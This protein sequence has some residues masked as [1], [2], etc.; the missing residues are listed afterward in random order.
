MGFF[1]FFKYSILGIVC[2]CLFR[3]AHAVYGSSQV[4]DLIRATAATEPQQ[5]LSHS[6]DNAGPLTHWA[7]RPPCHLFF[8]SIARSLSTLIIFS[9][10][11]FFVSLIFFIIFLLLFYWFLLLSLLFSIFC[12]LWVYSSFL[13]SWSENLDYWLDTFYLL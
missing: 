13:D 8:V 6:N 10:T 4:R 11:L 1:F 5:L 7:T 9:K 12:L 2:V 3:T